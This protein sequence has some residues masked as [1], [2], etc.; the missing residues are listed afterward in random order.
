M[1]ARRVSAPGRRR[2]VGLVGVVALLIVG[3]GAAIA[4]AVAG[5]DDSADTFV[6]RSGTSLRIGSK[7]FRFVGF[8]LYDAAATPSYSCARAGRLSDDELRA[9]LKGARD[10]AGASVLRFWAYQTYTRSGTDWS[11]VDRVLS[12]ARSE[13]MRVIPVLGDGPGNCTYG[14]TGVPKD[15]VDGGQWY[16]AGYR[17]PLFGAPLSYRDYV[18]RIVTHYANNPTILGWMMMNEAGTEARDADGRS[19]LVNFARDIAAEI[20]S[21]D[22]HHLVTVGT[23]SNGAPGASG[24]DFAAVY[25][26]A[27]VDFTEVHD[28]AFYGSDTL[29]MPG[30]TGPNRTTLPSVD[31]GKCQSLRAPIACSFAQARDV[32]HKPIIVGEAGIEATDEAGKVRRARLFAPKIAAAF[33]DGAA[34]YLI[35]HL[36]TVPTDNYDI[37]LSTNDPLLAVMRKAL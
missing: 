29:P 9:Q 7:E 19:Q 33:K 1:S 23:Q 11:G 17:T 21:I 30:A 37:I 27:D 32:L 36:D 28:Y 12:I 24:P 5:G 10:R 18:A 16:A 15:K 34:G 13:G 4:L 2:T 3:I 22:H 8:N 25:G 31:S 20:K 35:W 6:T 14:T 26:L